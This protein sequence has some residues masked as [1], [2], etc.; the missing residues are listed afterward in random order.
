MRIR[1]ITLFLA[2]GTA[3]TVACGSG[4]GPEHAPGGAPLRN[5]TYQAPP[6]TY[7]APGLPNPTD[8]DSPETDYQTPPDQ[9]E[10]G[11]PMSG[12]SVAA[13][14]SRLC[15]D[16]LALSCPGIPTDAT[17]QSECQQGCAEL[18]V[19]IPCPGPFATALSCILD[20]WPLTCEIFEEGGESALDDSI[21]ES[22][23]GPLEDYARCAGADPGQEPPPDGPNDCEPNSCRNCATECD[24]CMCDNDNDVEYCSSSCTSL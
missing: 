15:R 21:V 5:G 2:L 13:V 4:G 9:A 22:C 10:A 3:G 17:A 14:C 20:Y 23:R 8:Y 7:D 11:G 1:S 6:A 24:Q 19:E 16:I 18:E 12:G